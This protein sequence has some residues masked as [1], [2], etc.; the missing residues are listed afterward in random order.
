MSV[1]PCIIVLNSIHVEVSG[2]PGAVFPQEGQGSEWTA[3]PI[4]KYCV[5]STN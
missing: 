2:K 1:G 5:N 4:K 3:A